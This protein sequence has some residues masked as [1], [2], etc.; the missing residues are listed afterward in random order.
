METEIVPDKVA[1]LI[2]LMCLREAFSQQQI[3]LM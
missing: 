2:H 1:A 3:M